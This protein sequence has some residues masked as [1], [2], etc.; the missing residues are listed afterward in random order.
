VDLLF[1]IK[2]NIYVV[3]LPIVLSIVHNNKKRLLKTHNPPY[4]PSSC[5]R[6][7]LGYPLPPL[8]PAITRFTV[9]MSTVKWNDGLITTRRA[10][11]HDCSLWSILSSLLL[12]CIL[13]KEKTWTKLKVFSPLAPYFSG[14]LK[15]RGAQKYGMSWCLIPILLKWSMIDFRLF[16][17]CRQ[18]NRHSWSSLTRNIPL[19]LHTGPKWTRSATIESTSDRYNPPKKLTTP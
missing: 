3:P 15:P 12:R 11:G 16:D 10:Y 19:Q 14:G 1:I 6:P 9:E 7:S 4:Q 17:C 13:P 18:Q 8:H 2:I 5:T